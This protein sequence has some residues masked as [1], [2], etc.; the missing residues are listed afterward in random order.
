MNDD[1]LSRL[2]DL[3][4]EREASA[5]TRARHAPAPVAPPVVNAPEWAHLL[6]SRLDRLGERVERIEAGMGRVIARVAQ[7][8]GLEARLLDGLQPFLMRRHD[9]VVLMKEKLVDVA[10]DLQELRKELHE[11]LP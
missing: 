5:T 6:I 10:A 2:D 9:D 4:A 7:F 11:R 8:E 1:D 3:V